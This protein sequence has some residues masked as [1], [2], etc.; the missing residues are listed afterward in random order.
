MSITETLSSGRCPLPATRLWTSGAV[1]VHWAR[2]VSQRCSRVIGIDQDRPIITVARERTT[3][4]FIE[5]IE[6]DFLA[7]QFGGARFDLVSAVASIHHMPIAPALEKAAALLRPG[8]ILVVLGVFRGA[9]GD[10]FSIFGRCRTYERLPRSSS[11][12][13]RPWGTNRAS[14]DDLARSQGGSQAFAPRRSY[15]P[16]APLALPA[17]LATPIVQ[18]GIA[19]PRGS[20]PEADQGLGILYSD[21][22]C[23]QD[24]WYKRHSPGGLSRACFQPCSNMPIVLLGTP[25][26][27][28]IFGLVEHGDPRHE[29]I[30]EHKLRSNQV[31]PKSRLGGMLFVVD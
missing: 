1:T 9:E 17:Y 6:G 22:V 20:G 18:P 27:A 26:T 7:Y 2:E 15:S 4:P 11:G 8:G 12:L 29:I 23:R 10:R 5:F 31:D 16:I 14:R 3:S 30:K 28:N 13:V 19:G 21:T 25:M 24:R